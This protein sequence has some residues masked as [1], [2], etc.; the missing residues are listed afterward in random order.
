MRA[1]VMRALVAVVATSGVSA[2]AVEAAPSLRG[3]PAAMEEQNRVAKTH[4]LTFYRT[5]AAI[6]EAVERGELLRLEGNA[7]YDV[8][9]F[10][11]HPFAH[12]AAKLFVERLARQYHEACGQKLVVTSAT[13]PSDSQP[14]NSHALSVHP[15]GMAVDLRV[16]DR[17][18][19]RAWLE[20]AL[21]DMEAQGLLNG[22]R[23]RHPPHYHVALYPEPY[24]AYAVERMAEEAAATPVEVV[25]SEELA[26]QATL[27]APEI[28]VAD[29]GSS[30]PR[31]P[32]KPL[33]ATLALL[34]AWPL[35]RAAR[36]RGWVR[37]N[38]PALLLA[39]AANRKAE[40]QEPAAAVTLTGSDEV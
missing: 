33:M 6:E 26:E 15:A 4:G 22:I 28:V 21:M 9:D 20:N 30:L 35:S 32:L 13:R 11:R 24:M 17:A 40:Q 12:P 27:A 2:A 1:G 23:E 39:L 3:S 16:S 18:S 36:R 37:V 34:A 14:S 8:A 5:S 31:A 19:C 25:S 29:S 38:L 10:V 7:D